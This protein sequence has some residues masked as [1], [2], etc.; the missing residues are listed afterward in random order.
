MSQPA[1]STT[2]SWSSSWSIRGDMGGTLYRT[3]SGAVVLILLSPA[4]RGPEAKRPPQA[5]HPRPVPRPGFQLKRKPL[6]L[7][8]QPGRDTHGRDRQD[9]LLPT[10]HLS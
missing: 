5:T 10:A 3:G 8:L 1:I 4:E 2:S 7:E 6:A 9:R